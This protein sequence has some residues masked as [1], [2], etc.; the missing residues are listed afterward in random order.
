MQD[1]IINKLN[2]KLLNAVSAGTT[3]LSDSLDIQGISFY[4]FQ[5]SWSGFSAV[6]PVVTLYASNSL[7]EPFVQI[8][9]F[10]PSGTTGGR[11]VNVERAGYAYLKVGYSCASGAGTLTA[12]INGKV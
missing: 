11:I 10:I 1:F 4:S 3:I 9:S 2:V 5:T 7:T 8:D 12:S 6:S